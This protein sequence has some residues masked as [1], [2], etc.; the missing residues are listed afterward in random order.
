VWR[1]GFDQESTLNTEGVWLDGTTMVRVRDDQVTGYDQAGGAVRWTYPVPGRNVICALSGTVSGHI[2]LLGYA[3]DGDSCAHFVALDLTSGRVLWSKQVSG[4]AMP[5]SATPGLLAVSGSTAA[6]LD[7]DG[8]V[9]LDLRTGAARWISVPPDDCVLN[10]I[11]GGPVLAEQMTCD[12]GFRV[13]VV[14]QAT[15]NPAWSTLVPDDS[16]R[17][18]S[19]NFLA[20][21]PVTVHLKQPGTRGSDEVLSFDA[22]GKA[23][24]TIPVSGV[25]GPGGLVALDTGD[26]AFGA[27]PVQWAFVLRG[28]LVGVAESKSGGVFDVLAYRLS[29][30]ARLWAAQL[31]DSVDTI[32][33]AGDRVLVLGNEAPTPLL[34]SVSLATGALTD[35]GLVPDDLLAGDSQLIALGNE[36]ALVN[37][38]GIDPN[39]PVA[40]LAGG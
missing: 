38:V 40:L 28:V 24:A 5:I 8:L 30:G 10:S 27:L 7:S 37:K 36:F 9:G 26:Y 21:D 20:T 39:P 16:A 3:A 2:G 29:D 11:D 1:A 14:N 34:R 31:P 25:T 4:E 33:P 17:S 22:T 6:L 15:G 32:A 19:L 18:D 13:A 12:Q 23:G 35:I